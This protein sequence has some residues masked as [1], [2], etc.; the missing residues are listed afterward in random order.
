MISINET[1]HLLDCTQQTSVATGAGV[2]EARARLD[3]W[4][5][6]T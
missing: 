3:W 4:A 2:L 5:T 6:R 1:R